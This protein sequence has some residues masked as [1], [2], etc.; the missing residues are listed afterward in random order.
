MSWNTPKHLQ[1]IPTRFLTITNIDDLYVQ[2][3]A[4]AT[5]TTHD[6]LQHYVRL[7]DA[8]NSPVVISQVDLEKKIP[9]AKTLFLVL[10]RHARVANKELATRLTKLPRKLRDMVYTNLWGEHRLNRWR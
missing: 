10:D 7:F 2:Q 3:L 4:K 9:P 1:N 8:D 5:Q 6:Q